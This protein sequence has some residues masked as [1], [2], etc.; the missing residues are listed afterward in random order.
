MTDSTPG[1]GHNAMPLLDR[2]KAEHTAIVERIDQLV[3]AAAA[4][5]LKITDE[6]TNGKAIEL[7]KMLRVAIK[8]A[9]G[10]RE[11]EKEPFQQAGKQVD[12][13]FKIPMDR[14]KKAREDVLE[15][16]EEYLK[17]KAEEE[18][19]EREAKAKAERE[20]AERRRRE[21]DE[22]EARRREA[23]RQRIEEEERAARAKAERERAERERKEAEERAA[24][25]KAEEAEA[26]RRAVERAAREEK[27]RKERLAREAQERAEREEAER[28]RVA[29]EL[30]HRVDALDMRYPDLAD[31]IR[32]QRLPDGGYV[33]S[34][35]IEAELIAAARD[36]ERDRALREAEEARREEER[37]AEEERIAKL[38]AER[39]EAEREAAAAKERM[40]AARKEET[41]AKKEVRTLDKDARAAGREAGAHLREADRT[42]KR[43]DTMERKAAV[44][45]SD[46]ARQRTEHGAV[47]TLAERWEH[48][49]VDRSAIPPAV[50]FA[51][52]N[53]DELDAALARAVRGGV[54]DIPGVRITREAR[55]RAI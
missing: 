45:I 21:A 18:R 3:T 29:A 8:T 10:T 31:S 44:P 1:M 26:K 25:A 23:E 28:K 37:K 48:V 39:E 7:A 13:F 9:D 41:D 24:R 17:R 51:W 22:A 38:R 49:V 2:L 42:D 16:S 11:I 19:A 4:V 55:A 14:A 52:L 6:E 47:G 50:V 40:A 53:A 30:A 15:R 43:A 32:S 35:V 12:A 46:L 36:D 54:R 5:P 33:E 27:E 34:L 20:E